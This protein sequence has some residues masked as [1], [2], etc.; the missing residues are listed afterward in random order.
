MIRSLVILGCLLTSKLVLG[1]SFD[2]GHIELNTSRSL[3]SSAHSP[4]ASELRL[5]FEG[6]DSDFSW[7]VHALGEANVDCQYPCN[8][9]ALLD[10]AFIQYSK[11]NLHLT[12]GRQAIS[13]GNGLIFNPVDIFNPFDP[14][15]IDRKYKSGDDLFHAEYLFENGDNAQFLWVD[16]GS[17]YSLS[18]KYHGFLN[19]LEYDIIA[20]R[21][22]QQ[23][24]YSV[25]LS[26]PLGEWLWR[27]DLQK[28]NLE[29]GNSAFS[30]VSNLQTF[31]DI[32][33]KPTSFTLEYYHNG[34]G[35]DDVSTPEEI[36]IL[37]TRLAR[38]EVF[39]TADN[40][41]AIALNTQLSALWSTGLV[42]IADLENN[43][44]VSQILSQHS[45]A[46]DVE[47]IA[48]VNLPWDN[49]APPKNFSSPK[50]ARTISLQLAWY[51]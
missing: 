25:G 7:Q 2:G 17:E 13:W 30:A 15:A 14:L 6:R 29:N 11:D 44:A 5:K 27:A 33:G 43:H 28:Q 48:A 1:S 3:E 41:L 24:V 9:S 45:L 38:G 4:V 22:Y 40:Y 31:F 20:A 26:Y 39:G 16:H 19:E 46:T 47:L 35:V 12:L 42:H 8:N 34:L 37:L 36:S 18:T 50:P 21:H 49:S 10:R 32:A 51:F 23:S